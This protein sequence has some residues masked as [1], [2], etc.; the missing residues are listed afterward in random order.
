MPC[1]ITDETYINLKGKWAYYYRAI[2]KFGKIF[3][4]ML[5][6]HRNEAVAIMEG[7]E[8]ASD[9]LRHPTNPHSSNSPPSL[10]NCV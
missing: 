9:N 5:S 3:D 6:E 7:I 4:F 10:D 2:D 1:R 8:V